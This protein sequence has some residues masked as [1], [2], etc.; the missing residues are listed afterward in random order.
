MTPGSSGLLY[1]KQ[2]TFTY[3]SGF[4]LPAHMY[5]YIHVCHFR[6]HFSINPYLIPQILT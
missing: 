6:F 3:R 5:M 1:A 2:G 4:F